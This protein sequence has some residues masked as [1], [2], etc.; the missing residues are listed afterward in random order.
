MKNNELDHLT[1]LAKEAMDALPAVQ[2]QWEHDAIVDVDGEPISTVSIVRAI[3]VARDKAMQMYDILHHTPR[4]TRKRR[5]KN[6][7]EGE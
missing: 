4:A 6:G 3:R 7:E 1:A 5:A 2:L